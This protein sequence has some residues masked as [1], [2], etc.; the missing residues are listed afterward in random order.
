M[1]ER[2]PAVGRVNCTRGETG[3]PQGYLK[4]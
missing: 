4:Q 2:L 3:A 1:A